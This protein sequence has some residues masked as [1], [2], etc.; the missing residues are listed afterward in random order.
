MAA[1]RNPAA[2]AAKLLTPNRMAAQDAH[3]AKRRPGHAQIRAYQLVKS[4]SHA[5]YPRKAARELQRHSMILQA[6]LLHLELAQ[7]TGHHKQ[8]EQPSHSHPETK[9][10]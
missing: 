1:A 3:L 9:F 8:P 2:P 7:Q 6:C 10:L 5:L 4:Y